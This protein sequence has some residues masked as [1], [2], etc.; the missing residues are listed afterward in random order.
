MTDKRRQYKTQIKRYTDKQ[1]RVAE[2]WQTWYATPDGRF[3]IQNL[4]GRCWVFQDID[5]HDPIR[6][7]RA[8][9]ENNVG[10]YIARQLNLEPGVFAESM[11]SND[12]VAAS[13]WR[14]STRWARSC[15]WGMSIRPS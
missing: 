1:R 8:I 3:A 9:G 14:S 7:S 6:M 2:A 5:E 10:K 4:L 11:R 13:C 15:V 12:E